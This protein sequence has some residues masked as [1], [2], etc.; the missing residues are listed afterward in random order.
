[1]SEVKLYSWNVNGIRAAAKKGLAEWISTAKADTICLQETKAQDDQIPPNIT[2]QDQLQFY[3]HA[4]VKKGYS[5]VL[6]LCKITPES[7]E[8]E[9]GV[10]E[11][12]SEG[13]VVITKFENFTLCNVYFPNGKKNKERLDYKMRFYEQFF[14]FILKLRKNNEKV[15]FC[16]DINTA[17]KELDLAH[18]KPN[19]KYSGF[20]PIERA[21]IDEVIKNGFIDSFREFDKSPQKYSWWSQRTNARAKNVGWRIDYFFIDKSL[22]ENLIKAEIHS[23]VMGSDHCPI[24]ITLKF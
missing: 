6:T 1:M 19:S 15:I 12:D 16:G 9:L 13:R 5:G 23:D 11:F 14:K 8:F 17:H 2:E 20:L 22:R 7:V 10:E 3:H 18:P 21:W 4:A 24:S